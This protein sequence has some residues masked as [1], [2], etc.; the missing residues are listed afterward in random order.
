MTTNK[1]TSKQMVQVSTY[2]PYSAKLQLQTLAE[3]QGLSSYALIKKVLEDFLTR[4]EKKG[5]VAPV[6]TDDEKLL[7]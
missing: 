5:L 6:K 4:A 1:R 3:A 2:L 7:G